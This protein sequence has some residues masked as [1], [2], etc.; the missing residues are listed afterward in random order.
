MFLNV[1]NSFLRMNGKSIERNCDSGFD[2]RNKNKVV[3]M[4]Q[5]SSGEKRL[6]LILLTAFLQK[7]GTIIID[8][9]EM[10]LHTDWQELLIDGIKSL[11]EGLQIIVATHS[12][13]I[14]INGWQDKV[15]EITSI[16][17]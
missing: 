1:V 12:P 3:G 9:P 13:S 6:F 16:K 5:S 4:L 7:E 15:V 17:R 2:I 11:N 8:E 14:V 10:S